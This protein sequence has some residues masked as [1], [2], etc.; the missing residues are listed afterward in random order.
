MAEDPSHFEGI[1]VA[2]P[3]FIE[4]PFGAERRIMCHIANEGRM[5]LL[6]IEQ[7]RRCVARTPPSKWRE[8]QPVAF[9][10]T[11]VGDD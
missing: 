1:V 8:H 7:F 4:N 6:D 9:N 11:I 10:E 3:P 5:I 2:W